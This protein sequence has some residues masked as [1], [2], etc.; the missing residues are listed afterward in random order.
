[1]ITL[2]GT[3]AI[4]HGGTGADTANDALNNLLPDQVAK[5]GYVLT[6]DGANTYWQ[7][8]TGI[9]TVTCFS[10]VGA[11]GISVIVN[12]PTT[13]PEVLLGLGDI[14]PTSVQATGTI[15][16][17]NLS[18]TNTGDETA[19][20]IRTKLGIT[21]LSGANTGDQTITLTGDVTGSGTGTFDVTVS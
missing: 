13:T 10:A 3:L 14:T 16:G 5:D 6:T 12:T 20:S 11:N 18:G 2:D 4:E 17:Q 21:V 1:M 15:T 19:E 8:V 9:G 7:A